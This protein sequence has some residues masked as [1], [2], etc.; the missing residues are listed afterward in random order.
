MPA[1]ELIGLAALGWVASPAVAKLL[2]EGFTS[3][4]MMM[5][6]TEKRLAKL[7]STIFP[8]F[9]VVL[10]AAER[11]PHRPKVMKWLR[12]LKSAF[13]DAEDA[14]DLL[15]YQRLKRKAAAASS[16][17]R[18]R[19]IITIARVRSLFRPL[20]R[21]SRNVLSSR[22]IK[23]MRRLSKLE[24]IAGE[25]E[26]LRDLLG[27]QP[28]RTAARDGR[29]TI[30]LPP[31]GVFGRDSDCEAIIRLL[32]TKHRQEGVPIIAI[33]GRPGV[34]KT[35]LAQ[36]VCERLT[37]EFGNKHFD[38]VVWVYASRNFK[39]SEI[40]KNIIQQASAA[41]EPQSPVNPNDLPAVIRAHLRNLDMMAV[42]NID[43]DEVLQRK[44]DEKLNSKKFLL[45]IDDVWCDGEDHA[46]NW[47][48]LLRC[49]SKCSLGSKILVTSQTNDAPRKMGTA[50]ENIYVLGELEEDDFLD[51]FIHHALNGEGIDPSV[52]EDLEKIGKTIA[53]RLDR[54]PTAAKIVGLCLQDKLQV[55][56]WTETAEKDWSDDKTKALMWSY[57]HL[58]AHLQRCFAYLNLYPKGYKFKDLEVFQ[59]WMAQGFIKPAEQ[60]A[61]MEDVG[62]RY[63]KELVSRF[64]VQSHGS[65]YTLHELLYDLAEK[66]TCD[67][68]LK[69]EG[70]HQ[71]K[72]PATIRHLCVPAS[73]LKINQ[74][75]ICKLKKLRTLIVT[76]GE[77]SIASKGKVATGI[78]KS[79]RRLRVLVLELNL[80]NLAEFISELK[81]LRILQVSDIS[82]FVLP[83]SACTLYQL[84][85]LRIKSARSIP[86]CLDNFVSL[87]YLEPPVVPDIG[88][89]TSLQGLEIFQV[90]KEKGYEL[91]QLQNLNELR[92]RLRIDSLENVESKESAI[93]ANLKE[94][95]YL[96]MLQLVWRDGEDNVNSN[97]DVEILEG[98]QLPP[99]LTSLILD[100]YRGR[101]CPSWPE[102]QTSDIQE[103]TLER[104]RMLEE[105]PPMEQLYPSCRSLEL[106]N[107]SKLKA[108]H[109]LPPSLRKLTILITP[110]LTF[111]TKED[112][113]MSQ[114]L[115]AS[116]KQVM[117]N[118]MQKWFPRQ[119]QEDLV[120]KG[121]EMRDFLVTMNGSDNDASSPGHTSIPADIDR[122]LR[123]HEQKME[124]IYS[125]RNEA[126]LLLPSTLTELWL[127][128][129]SITNRALS[130]CLQN[131][132]SLT[133]LS[134]G[135]IRTIT[136][137][138]SA[139]VLGKLTS[140]QAIILRGC[141]AVTSLGGI[142]SL[143]HLKELYLS[144]C[145][146]LDSKDAF[147]PPS[148]EST[149]FLCCAN[150]DDI[151][152][153]ADL[154][155]LS[156]LT[157]TQCHMRTASLQFGNLPSLHS[158][159]VGHCPGLSFSVDVQEL[160]SLEFLILQNCTNLQA[161]MNLPKSLRSLVIRG[162]PILEKQSVKSDSGV[163]MLGGFPVE[164]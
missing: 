131:L 106:C 128:E 38:L 20:L 8:V 81:H 44:M 103:L 29:Q 123:L 99:N 13:H 45:V 110:V 113:Q 121:R 162:C 137:L 1:A 149:D 93:A 130:A 23:L 57:Q 122:W 157:I 3:L 119:N 63:L 114:E 11:S 98:L 117:R 152:A 147:L 148:L 61:R 92:G 53:R 25:A 18:R 80:E 10:D 153:N 76:S 74:E 127:E 136:R 132:T 143:P 78:F 100:G 163:H 89:L 111:V 142:R 22:K 26:K 24:A 129:C 150:V 33:V 64:Y 71:K 108:L 95:K 72:I 27:V 84:Q 159:R 154:P 30:S 151:L 28:D 85:V 104:C 65:Y 32:E 17:R 58:P 5:I 14:L 51:L 124:L 47:D 139:D 2:S 101:S 116:I 146:C 48:T 55:R 135:D 34:G 82:K 37:S 161:V 118:R 42:D 75:E 133:T 56:Y 31:R 156:R 86:K 6:N 66:V 21:G 15:D 36:Y 69:I 134:L 94:K 120:P 12:R 115:K 88:K 35:T 62:S 9:E 49:L 145:P 19:S 109:T 54:D 77:E 50:A 102:H 97:L 126:K 158:L 125:R 144:G 96:D 40:M 160:H 52:R 39:A 16:R 7:E 87:R 73:K 46:H 138:P 112:L 68:C 155:R 164:Q 59:F 43:S 105:L 70:N 79:L 67:D 107:L 83:K 141:W 60:D 90:R 41:S 140:L 91:E 4:G